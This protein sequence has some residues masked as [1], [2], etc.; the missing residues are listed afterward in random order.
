[1]SKNRQY[2]N[3]YNPHKHISKEEDKRNEENK[4]VQAIKETTEILQEET[5]VEEEKVEDILPVDRGPIRQFALVAGAKRVNMRKAPNK[6]GAIM[7]TL[8]ENTE[9]EILEVVD[10]T[11]SKIGYQGETGYMMTMYLKPEN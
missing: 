10:R 3:F 9:V 7:R 2:N 11:W 1:M 8:D 6:D 4:E 5:P